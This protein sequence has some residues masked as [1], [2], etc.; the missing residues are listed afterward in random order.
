[1]WDI[2]VLSGREIDFALSSASADSIAMPSVKPCHADTSMIKSRIENA[3]AHNKEHLRQCENK[4]EIAYLK[5]EIDK[6]T[7][8]HAKLEAYLAQLERYLDIEEIFN[9][10]TMRCID[11]DR[12][13]IGDGR[14]L[15]AAFDDMKEFL[16]R[17]GPLQHSDCL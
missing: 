3:I 16:E 2:S 6:L 12:H 15:R 1:M 17:P 4:D 9:D 14:T 5:G 13:I 7:R 10:C 8:C 11:P